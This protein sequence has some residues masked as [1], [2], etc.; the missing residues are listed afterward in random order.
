[1][2]KFCGYER[3]I[4]LTDA[5]HARHFL[6]H[7]LELGLSPVLT[8]E[9]CKVVEGYNE[10]DCRATWHLREWVEAIRAEV[11]AGGRE[12]SRPAPKD[13]SQS[14]EVGAHQQRVAALFEALTRDVPTEP[15]D[16]NAEQA[17]RW[18]LAHALDW[19][20]REEKVKWW[21]FFRMK[22]LSEEELLDEKVAVAGLVFT[23]RMPKR[24]ARERSPID[25]YRYPSQ[26]CSIRTG[27]TLFTLDEQ[28]FGEVVAADLSA[29]ALDVKKPIKLDGLHP[30]SVFAHTHY[31]TDEQSKSILRIADWIVENGIDSPG[32]YRAARDLLLRHRPR[33]VQ[34]HSLILVANESVVQSACR[35][36]LPLDSSVLP[37]Q[38]PP[39]AGKTFTGA[40][41]ICALVDQGKKV[42]I[43]AVSHK[44]IRKLLDEVVDAAREMGITRLVCGHR[45]EAADSG[46]GRIRE[47]G[48]ND[49]ALH[50]LEGDEG[51]VLG[52]SEERR[53]GK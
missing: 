48:R 38:G 30:K 22:D 39:G 4:A 32:P 50:A 18:L 27:D 43:T 29:R 42:G 1:M 24:S 52:R 49:E 25:Q 44:V 53:V 8:D 6:E 41:M 2:E 34:G 3:R 20:R 13:L 12:I 7:Q 17:A 45:I 47:L 16:R 31:R 37:I 9:A 23:Q 51:N 15:A 10:D 14:E 26:E 19:H 35:V 46:D 33:L 28:K 5:N 11:V 40:R 21:E 36:G